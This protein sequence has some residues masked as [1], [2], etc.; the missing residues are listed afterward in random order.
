MSEK[1][2]LK[3][4]YGVFHSPCAQKRTNVTVVLVRP[5]YGGNIGSIARAMANFGI[6]SPLRIVARSPEVIDAECRKMAVHAGNIIDGAAF[7]PSLEDLFAP[8]AGKKILRVAATARIASATRAHP[9][10][11]DELMPV[12][13]DKVQAQELEEIFFVFGCEADGLSNEEVAACDQVVTIPSVP[14]YRSLNLS[15]A[16]MVFLYEWNRAQ[17]VEAERPVATSRSQKQKLI[18]HFLSLAEEVGFVLPGDPFK[19]RPRLE[20]ILSTLPPFLP[21]VKTLHGLLD[22]ISRSLKKGAP[23]VR[24]RYRRYWEN[25]PGAQDGGLISPEEPLS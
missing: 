17:L 25:P 12:L 9:Q 1:S 6:T 21:E 18:A 16:V 22:Q 10:R 19:M 2:D 24:G 23:D 14:E 15:Q 7:H 8:F 13:W 5:E 20:T 11:V 4:G 3:K